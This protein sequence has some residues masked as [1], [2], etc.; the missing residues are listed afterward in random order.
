VSGSF[1][2]EDRRVHA[3]EVMLDTNVDATIEIDA[4]ASAATDKDFNATLLSAQKTLPPQIVLGIPVVETLV[5]GLVAHCHVAAS[6]ELDADG[7]VT[8]HEHIRLGA[9]WDGTA[10]R[11][12]SAFDPI[13]IGAVGPTISAS[14]T[15][16]VTCSITP[17]LSVL[18]Y[19]VVGPYVALSPSTSVKT[20]LDVDQG[21]TWELDGAIHAELGF[22]EQPAI[23]GLSRLLSLT[24]LSHAKLPLY[25]NTW[26]LAKTP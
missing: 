15:A 6:G 14:A 19:D 17:K 8:V 16:M 21:L 13:T 24:G 9:K 11:N 20:S 7:G 3:F 18:L 4:S 22:D 23:P 5:F 2:L 10:W 26:V 25:D 1:D 12:E